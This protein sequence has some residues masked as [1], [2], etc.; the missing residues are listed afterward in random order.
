MASIDEIDD[1]HVSLGRMLTVQ[2]AS[3][4]LQRTL[5]RHGHCQHQRVERGVIESLPD[6][7]A[8]RL[9]R[10]HAAKTDVRIIDFVDTGHPALLRMWDRRQRGY[11]AMGYRIKESLAA[12]RVVESDVFVRNMHEIEIDPPHRK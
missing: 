9:H 4:L 3:V 10:E 7:L 8:G 6:Q 11:K 2:A 5:P 1:S 12:D